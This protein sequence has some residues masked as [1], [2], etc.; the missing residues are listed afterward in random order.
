M[1][2]ICQPSS[3]TAQFQ[4]D[5]EPDCQDAL[6]SDELDCQ[7][8]PCAAGEFTCA[9]SKCIPQ[10]QVCNGVNDCKDVNTSD[11]QQSLCA[12]KNMTC[13]AG[14]LKCKTTTIC[15]EPYWVSRHCCLVQFP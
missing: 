7:Y 15:V 3:L 9:N 1:V 4:C 12:S 6:N 14:Q 11:E 10:A 2:L 5:H 13:P 8:P